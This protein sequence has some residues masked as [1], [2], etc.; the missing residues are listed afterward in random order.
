MPQDWRTRVQHKPRVIALERARKRRHQELTTDPMFVQGTDAL[1]RQLERAYAQNPR[2]ITDFFHK[3]SWPSA[4]KLKSVN[5]FLRNIQNTALK[6]TLWQYVQYANRFRVVFPFQK[7]SPHFKVLELLPAGA[8]FHVKIVKGQLT[9]TR[10]AYDEEPVDSSFESEET[11][12]PKQLDK[13]IKRGQAK[14]VCIDDKEGSSCLSVI[15]HVT[16]FPEG[17]TFVLHNAEQPYV[18][19]LIGEKISVELWRQLSKTVTAIFR[20][21]FGRGKAGRPKDLKKLKQA[22]KLLKK[23]GPLK[24][25]AFVLGGKAQNTATQQ[26]YLSRLRKEQKQ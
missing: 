7:H 1:T 14:F 16:Y 6:K 21:K 22:K 23:A 4:S 3:F 19:C 18:L 24:E 26:S 9:P 8:K 10:P 25:K 11:E 13:A 17:I 20:M 5:A 2:V 15:E 12:V